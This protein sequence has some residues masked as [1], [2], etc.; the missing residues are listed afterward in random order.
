MVHLFN[1]TPFPWTNIDRWTIEDKPPKYTLYTGLSLANYFTLFLAINAFHTVI[2]Y[3][4][5]IYTS[6]SFKK[7]GFIKQAIHALENTTIPL[8]FLDWDS[9]PGTIE[10][11]KKRRLEVCKEVLA[12][13]GINKIIGFSMLV[14]LVFTGMYLF[15][16]LKCKKCNI[17]CTVKNIIERHEILTRSIGTRPEED[18]SYKTCQVLPPLVFVFFFFGS[19]LEVFFYL[20]FNYKVFINKLA[21][22]HLTIFIP[23]TP[24]EGDDDER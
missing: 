2:I 18:I 23:G 11:H 8:S 10:E 6:P 12:T 14:P 4:V 19:V 15:Y 9:E 7:A 22:Q 16:F 13:L 1:T 3:I 17:F 24:L 20:L 5:K 21:V